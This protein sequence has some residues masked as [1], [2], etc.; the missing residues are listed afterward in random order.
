MK[1]L[2]AAS[3][4]RDALDLGGAG[5]NVNMRDCGLN[6]RLT[7]ACAETSVQVVGDNTSEAGT[8]YVKPF[9]IEAEL[10]RSVLCERPDDKSWVE[11]VLEANLEYP[12]S[13][14]LVIQPIASTT[15]WLGDSGVASVTLPGSPTADDYGAAVMAA[16][17]LWFE[18][19]MTLEGGP[20]MH[21]PPTL[22]PTL[23]KA[24][25]LQMMPD[26]SAATILGD[27][28]VIAPGYDRTGARVFFSGPI[29][30]AYLPVDANDLLRRTR[31]NDSVVVANTIA[32]IDTP[33]CAIVRV[34][35]YS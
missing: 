14:A 21:V 2:E 10:R 13:R 33:P 29:K 28:V 32:I 19:V 1:L 6:V 27:K 20:I 24:G 25:V 15:S 23:V 12:L 5:Y 35:T 22:V 11:K 9:A 18:T 34:G 26:G 3:V 8:Y 17:K 31:T 16:R 4:N 7:D 30:I